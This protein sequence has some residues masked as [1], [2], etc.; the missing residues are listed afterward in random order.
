LT[1]SLSSDVGTYS[2]RVR[3]GAR[4]RLV[5]PTLNSDGSPKDI[6]GFTV[7]AKIKT[8]PGGVVLYTWPAEDVDILGAELQLTIPAPTSALWTWH[9]GWYRVKVTDPA[10][11][12]ED[13]A[14]TRLLQGAIYLDLD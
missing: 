13:P 8:E 2:W 7:D 11:P 10:S 6:T 5:I 4:E 12:A 9:A 14:V 3:Q 1:S